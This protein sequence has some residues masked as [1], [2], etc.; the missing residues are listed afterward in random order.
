MAKKK[1]AKKKG[2][3]S[4]KPTQAELAD[5]HDLYESAVQSPEADCE[6]FTQFFRELRGRKPKLLREDFCGTAKL[7]RTW[8]QSARGRKAIGIDFDGPTVAQ[9]RRR[10]VEPFAKQLGDRL[11]LVEADVLEVVPGR[12]E[13]ADLIAALNFSFCVFKQREQLRRYFAN[14]FGGRTRRLLRPGDFD[15]SGWF[16]HC[17]CRRA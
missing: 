13:S 12:V 14:A 2:S 7:S 5:R 17:L 15:E 6:L 8:C 9:A 1:M 4:R 3:T 16:A 11:Q 10:N